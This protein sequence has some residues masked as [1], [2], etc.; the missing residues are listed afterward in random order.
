[1]RPADFD[2]EVR[3]ISASTGEPVPEWNHKLAK[4]N[5]ELIVVSHMW[6]EIR[7]LMWNY[8]GIV[9][10]DRAFGTGASPSRDDQAR[11]QRVLLGLPNLIP[12]SRSFGT[13]LWSR[14]SQFRCAMGRQESRGIH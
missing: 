8:V 6:E 12:T 11:T 14:N 9:R 3:A 13:A 1:M 10:T 2:L 4:D 7:R 5:D